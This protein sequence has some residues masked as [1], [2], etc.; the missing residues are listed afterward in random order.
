MTSRHEAGAEAEAEAE[1]EVA[2]RRLG[3]EIPEDLKGGVLHGYRGLR[4][5]TSLL[6][7]E[8]GAGEG[9]ESRV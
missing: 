9:G 3:I 8:P 1:L 5:M 7:D 2:A 6:R 4:E